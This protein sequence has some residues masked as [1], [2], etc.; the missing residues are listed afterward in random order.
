MIHQLEIELNKEN[1]VELFNEAKALSPNHI[2]ALVEQAKR[3]DFDMDKKD[4]EKLY[5]TTVDV[6]D[7]GIKKLIKRK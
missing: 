3:Q 2:H 5:S 6:V 1:Y 4:E 7:S